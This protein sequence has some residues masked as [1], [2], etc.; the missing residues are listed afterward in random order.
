MNDWHTNDE[1]W[2]M[3]DAVSESSVSEKPEPKKRAF[4]QTEKVIL[5]TD[6]PQY[7]SLLFKKKNNINR[8]TVSHRFDR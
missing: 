1:P 8:M 7:Y 3:L 4:L 2:P 5:N 6:S